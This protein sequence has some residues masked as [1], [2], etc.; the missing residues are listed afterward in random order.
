VKYSLVEDREIQGEVKSRKGKVLVPF[1]RNKASHP[2]S[3]A[4]RLYKRERNRV[5][6]RTIDVEKNEDTLKKCTVGSPKAM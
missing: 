3:Q 4:A 5:E 2:G 6:R 1:R